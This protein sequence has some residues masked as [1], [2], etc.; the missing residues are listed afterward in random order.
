MHNVHINVN[1]TIV[2]LKQT[3]TTILRWPGI[4]FLDFSWA[5]Q[6]YSHFTEVVLIL[7]C[8]AV[9]AITNPTVRT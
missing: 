1:H 6:Q 8:E 4:G 5:Q 7:S 2:Q 9:I 3:Q